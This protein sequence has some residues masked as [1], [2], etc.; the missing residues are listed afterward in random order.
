MLVALQ[1]RAVVG[2]CA[3]GRR[4][5]LCARQEVASCERRNRLAGE[6][7]GGRTLAR[8]RLCRPIPFGRLLTVRCRRT[9][10]TAPPRT[11]S[12]ALGTA[13][14]VDAYLWGTCPGYR[15]AAAALSHSR[16]D[17]I[18]SDQEPVLFSG[19]IAYNILYALADDDA[20][21]TVSIVC[22]HTVRRPPAHTHTH[23]TGGGQP[24]LREAMQQ[25]VGCGAG[26]LAASAARMCGGDREHQRLRVRPGRR[27]RDGGGRAWRTALRSAGPSRPHSQYRRRQA[28]RQGQPHW[29]GCAAAGLHM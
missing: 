17:R 20:P 13:R 19:T 22:P 6:T 23:T 28:A 5:L 9:A 29:V 3:A 1:V 4:G 12:G 15:C 16:S 18:G 7:G 26:R 21:D 10:R 11:T 27:L 24:C 8:A 2:A 25:A 14:T